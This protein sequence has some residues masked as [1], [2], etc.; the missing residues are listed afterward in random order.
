MRQKATKRIRT[1][2]AGLW[3][4]LFR[5][6]AR[7][8]LRE[9]G[10]CEVGLGL[11]SVVRGATTS[12]GVLRV[13]SC[14]LMSVATRERLGQMKRTVD[15]LSL[16]VLVGD[17][18]RVHR[19]DGEPLSFG[20]LLYEPEGEPVIS[21]RVLGSP[22]KGYSTHVRLSTSCDGPASASRRA[23]SSAISVSSSTVARCWDGS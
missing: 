9:A 22:E 20:L 23:D 5:A 16:I 10:R 19:R 21:A 8:G 15:K 14:R 1:A 3:C 7:P 6:S 17:R 13:C 12:A 2:L 11:H 4:R 18:E